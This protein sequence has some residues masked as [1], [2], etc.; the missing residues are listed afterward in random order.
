[1]DLQYADKEVGPLLGAWS[2]ICGSFLVSTTRPTY[3]AYIHMGV[4]RALFVGLFVIVGVGCVGSARLQ[5]GA[6][7]API[8]VYGLLLSWTAIRAITV[9]LGVVTAGTLLAASG[10]CLIGCLCVREGVVTAQGRRREGNPSRQSLSTPRARSPIATDQASVGSTAAAKT[11][12][13]WWLAAA[14]LIGS[15]F[16]IPV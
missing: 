7:G 8:A 12:W 13:R 9:D 6:L 3:H 2:V 4:D 1:M 10:L 5:D 16:V 11:R 14:L 15:G